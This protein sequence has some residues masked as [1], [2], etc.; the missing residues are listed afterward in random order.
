MKVTLY[1][2]LGIPPTASDK[3]VRVALRNLVRQYYL[4]TR[5]DQNEIEEALRFVNHASHILTDK[6]LRQRYDEEIASGIHIGSDAARRHFVANMQALG[7]GRSVTFTAGAEGDFS[8]PNY[9][10]QKAH[11]HGLTASLNLV[12]RGAFYQIAAAATLIPLMLLAIWL[13]TPWDNLLRE[14]QLMLLWALGGAVVAAGIYTLVSNIAQRRRRTAEPFNSAVAQL[15]ILK[16]RKEKTVFMGTF[17]PLEDP[18]WLFRLR[19]VELERTQNTRTSGVRPWVRLAA[20]LFDYGLW[21]VALT[22][23]YYLLAYAGMISPAT[24]STLTHPMLAPVLTTAT[25]VPLETVL[26]VYLH[27]TPGKW[28]FGVYVQFGVSSAHTRPNVRTRW[29]SSFRRAV[30]VWLRGMGCGI[31]VLSLALMA[32]GKEALMN[33]LETD[34]DAAEDCLVTHSPVGRLNAC[35]G[36]TGLV[37][38]IWIT[39]MAWAEPMQATAREVEAFAAGLIEETAAVVK[40]I[41]PNEPTPTQLAANDVDTAPSPLELKRKRWA[42]WEAESRVLGTQKNYRQQA[43]ICQ[44][45]ADEDFR[46]PAA[47]KCLGLA[48]QALGQ[49]RQAVEALQRAARYDPN[50]KGV[51]DAIVRSFRSQYG[52]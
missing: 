5:D 43:E 31:P 11:H 40:R 19:M 44:Q 47:W 37:A 28:L 42:E 30:H 20:R 33:Q 26:Q 12:A 41:Q 35:T 49:H 34:W 7:L 32:L 17:E 21:G 9:A 46:N 38:F 4:N 6:A 22:A 1:E 14:S 2:A 45:W 52:R 36:L 23:L 48:R 18:T 51:Q 29:I 50:D 24:M 27:T 13:V 39:G 3:A 10:Q 15:T 25:W 16:W 8:S